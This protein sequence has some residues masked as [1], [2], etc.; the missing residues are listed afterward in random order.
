MSRFLSFLLFH[1]MFLTLSFAQTAQEHYARGEKQM[2][3]DKLLLELQ[4]LQPNEILFR[5][6]L[7]MA[8]EIFSTTKDLKW[9]SLIKIYEAAMENAKTYG[10]DK[11]LAAEINS[12]KVASK[13]SWTPKQA[14]DLVG[15]GMTPETVLGLSLYLEKKTLD[16]PDNAEWFYLA[17][18]LLEDNRRDGAKFL[19]A[20]LEKFSI[21]D[22]TKAKKAFDLLTTH[23]ALS[24]LGE[25]VPSEIQK[26]LAELKKKIK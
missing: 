15:P 19:E 18:K 14:A 6:K 4:K 21:S 9:E 1:L 25:P 13:K 8:N 16:E 22:K 11:K 3:Y 26:K 17:G 12:L 23:Y 20:Y 2:A 24:Y 10:L 7:Q 5:V